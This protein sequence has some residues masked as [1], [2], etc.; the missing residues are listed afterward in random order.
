[1]FDAGINLF[2]GLILFFIW[3]IQ[4]HQNYNTDCNKAYKQQ[5][6]QWLQYNFPLDPLFRRGDGEI[7]L[8]FAG[9]E[10]PIFLF[11][12]FSTFQQQIN[13]H[14][15]PMGNQFWEKTVSDEI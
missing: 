13:I 1:M 2:F 4:L 7:Q 6:F 5:F 14:T 11:L 9:N 8:A 12:A 10:I 15:L 3:S